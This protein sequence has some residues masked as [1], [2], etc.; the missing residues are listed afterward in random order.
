MRELFRVVIFTAFYAYATAVTGEPNMSLGAGSFAVFDDIKETTISVS[1]LTSPVE[2][3]GNIQLTVLA[4]FIRGNGYYI[5]TGVMKQFQINPD[6]SW[7]V[8]FSG[9]LAHESNASQ[10]L[11]YDV[12]FY[13]RILLTY[14]V[15]V[16]N[17]IALEL[18]HVS[19]GGLDSDNPGT[20]PLILRW[21]T[22]F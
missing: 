11:S 14:Q 18:G 5:G 2:D 9:G 22:T 17:A 4:L 1:Y 8:G 3:W 13:S 15:S 7:G 19:N 20:E 6:W 10:T 21:Y 16:D 12:N